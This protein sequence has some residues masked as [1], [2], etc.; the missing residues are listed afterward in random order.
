M[1]KI[2][3]PREP[4][5]M[6]R[7]RAC[8]ETRDI[9]DYRLFKASPTPMYMDFC[10]ICEQRDG[11]LTLYRRFNAYGTQEIIDAVYAAGRCPELRLSPEQIRLLVKP[12]TTRA[13]E[14]NEEVI[15]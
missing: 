11:T 12:K 6:A 4:V 3:K 14:S 13:P 5:L 7:C 9:A 10:S 2:N 1:K 8:G 15:T